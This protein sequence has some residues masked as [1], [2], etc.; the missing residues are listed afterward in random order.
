MAGLVTLYFRRNRGWP[1]PEDSWGLTPM[2]GDDGWCRGCGIPLREQTG[3]IVLGSKGLTGAQGAWIPYWRSNV[4]CM[5]R[6]LGE[7]L[8]ARSGLPLRPVAWPRQGTGE[9]VQVLIPVVGAPW[10]DPHELR[11]RTRARHG[12]AGVT[13]R[14]CGTWRWMPLSLE[15]LPP[16]HVGPELA[17]APMAASPEWFGDGWSSFH[18]LLVVRELAELIRRASP[19]DFTVEE[20]AQVDESSS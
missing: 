4:L 2:Y 9:A 15:E 12:V 3:S 14:R 8:A 20:V 5:H 13:C 1:K 18:K 6:A 10:F 7:D 17:A 19:R 16:V 11:R